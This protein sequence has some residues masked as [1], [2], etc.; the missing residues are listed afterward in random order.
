MKKTNTILGFAVSAV[1]LVVGLPNTHAYTVNCDK[2][3]AST[4]MTGIYIE[5]QERAPT[6]A[7]AKLDVANTTMSYGIKGGTGSFMRTAWAQMDMATPNESR[8]LYQFVE[9][10]DAIVRIELD[11]DRE[12]AKILTETDFEVMPGCV[13][14][15]GQGTK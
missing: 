12:I 9:G 4:G 7:T 1:S 8:W 11:F 10:D 2:V 3:P 15:K 13:F 6:A 14:F 5:A